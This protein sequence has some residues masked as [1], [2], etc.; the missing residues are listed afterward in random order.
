[1]EAKQEFFL[2]TEVHA[3]LQHAENVPKIRSRFGQTGAHCALFALDRVNKLITLCG[4]AYNRILIQPL[5][6]LLL[7]V[8]VALAVVAAAA[9][10]VAGNLGTRWC[11][12]KTTA[13][14]LLFLL[15]WHGN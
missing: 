15:L 4:M 9:A 13:Q 2:R 3:V 7:N 11:L 10:T 8:V 12:N 1:M 6:K 5:L 14:L